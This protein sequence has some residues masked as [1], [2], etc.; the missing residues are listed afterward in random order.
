MMSSELEL[1]DNEA[2]F[3]YNQAVGGSGGGMYFSG[4]P[5][6]TIKNV[7]LVGNVRKP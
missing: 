4:V 1:K 3:G 7:F 2:F 5:R 6:L